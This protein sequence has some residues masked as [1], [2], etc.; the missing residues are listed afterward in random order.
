MPEPLSPASADL[1]ISHPFR[2]SALSPRKP[3]RF[4]LAP[5]AAALDLLA[6]LLGITAVRKLSFR[7]EIRPVGRNDYELEAVLEA[8]VEQ[9]C[10]VSLAPVVTTIKDTIHR[11]YLADMVFPDGDEIEMP[12]DDSQEPL[13]DVIDAGAVAAEALALALPQYPRAPGA[14]LDEAVFA[15]PGTAPLR[16]KDL[17]P[18]AG[19]AGLAQKLGKTDKDDNEG[20]E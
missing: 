18:F 3:T 20:A 13:P 14:A 17:R 4:A 19:L 7:G 6:Q 15:A 16:D 1:P 8:T 9:P 12:E 11:K 5:D 10:I 2:T